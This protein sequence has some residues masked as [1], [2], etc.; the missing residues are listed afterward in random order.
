[1]QQAIQKANE[2]TQNLNSEDVRV[3][4]DELSGNSITFPDDPAKMRSVRT[5]HYRITMP[6]YVDIEQEI[7]KL[8][9]EQKS[10]FEDYI[11]VVNELIFGKRNDVI[12]NERYEVLAK[13][14]TSIQ[15]NLL[16]YQQYSKL[17]PESRNAMIHPPQITRISKAKRKDQVLKGGDPG[18][19]PSIVIPV[20][21]FDVNVKNKVKTLLQSKYAGKN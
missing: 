19:V 2:W 13:R 6:V 20:T 14:L 8:K 7:Y 16:T 17:N 21:H 5:K 9:Q 10:L 1:M 11:F 12:M 4:L 3:Y 15:Q 18:L